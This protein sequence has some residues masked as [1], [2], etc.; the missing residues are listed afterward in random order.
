MK[1]NKYLFTVLIIILVESLAM[2]IF[3]FDIFPSKYFYDSNG[4]LKLISGLTIA[5]SS[6]MFAANFYKFINIFKFDSLEQWSY[7]LGIV[8]MIPI[9]KIMMK[10][11]QYD[12][13][14]Y[15]FIIMSIALLNLYIFTLSKDFIQY[16]LFFIIYLILTNEKIS[17]VKKLIFSCIVLVLESLFFR[18]Y[19]LLMAIIMVTIYC[20]YLFFIKNKK[21][22]KKSFIRLIFLSVVL[23]FAEVFLVQLVS[24]DNYYSIMYARSSVNV[25]RING[26]IDAQTIIKELFGTNTTFNIFVLNYLLNFVRLL[27]PVELLF[28]S[29]KYLPF[30]VY[31]IIICWIVIKNTKQVNDNN[32]L[33]VITIL[34][35]FM[36]STIFEPDFGSFIRHESAMFLILLEM[37]NINKNYK[38]RDVNEE[39]RNSNFSEN[40]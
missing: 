14:Q 18:V 24:T 16:L 35:F 37:T 12:V 33:F 23:F 11:K 3:M 27:I 8:G 25:L 39:N 19:Y 4:I 28:K 29:V 40:N 17:N 38:V 2:K 20:V 13:I 9:V 30:V 7:F 31:Q 21:L 26:S 10:N 1:I 36:I 15:I 5:D 32:V 34:S 6:Y 22:D